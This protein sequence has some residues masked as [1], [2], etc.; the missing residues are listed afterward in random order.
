M[1]NVD[2]RRIYFDTDDVVDALLQKKITDRILL[3]SSLYIEDLAMNFDVRPEHIAHPVPF[4]IAR[5][6]MC[7]ALMTAA[8][9]NSRM[10]S[11]GQQDGADA[12][13]L[14]RRVFAEELKALE[15]Q[16]SAETFTDGQSALAAT[17]PMSVPFL[18]G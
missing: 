17:Y 3:K 14:K 18:R 5:L 2:G 9:E 16:L 13:E 15:G 12:Y 4:K 7:Y 1:D 10:A 11:N 8:L 6:A